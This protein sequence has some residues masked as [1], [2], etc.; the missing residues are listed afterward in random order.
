MSSPRPVRKAVLPVAGLGTRILPATKVLPKEMLTLV[1]KPLIQYAVEEAL[2]AGIEEICFVSARNKTAMEDHFDV[3]KEL[4][5]V[6]E[7]RGKTA[8]LA[9]VRAATLGP[10]KLA[11][12][13]QQHPLGLGHAVHCAASFVGR[14]PFAILLPDE[15]VLADTGCLAQ[16]VA[17]YEA[18]GG[19]VLAAMDVPREHTG[20]YGILATGADDGSVAEVTGMVEKPAPADAPSTLSLTGRYI[21][22]PEVMDRLADQPPGAGGE[23]Q[24][25]DAMARLIG[26]QPFTAVRFAGQRLDAGNKLGYIEATLAFALARP[27]LGADVR[28]MMARLLSAAEEG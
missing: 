6:L 25:T 22:Q 19:N 11:S 24:L 16:L 4:E 15:L 2:E 7:A 17:V 21:L 3:A 27:D 5:T 18:R 28:A 13:R 23:I 8:E 1:D 12:V 10:G 20:R 14:E 9:A 26:E